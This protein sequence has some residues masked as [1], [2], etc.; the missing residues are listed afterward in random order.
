MKKRLTIL[1]IIILLLPNFVFA[2]VGPKP[3]L[4]I[5]VLGLEDYYLDLLVQVEAEHSWLEISEEERENL[6]T[7]ADYEDSQGYHPALL[8]GTRIPIWGEIVGERVGDEKYIH[9]FSYVGV[10]DN[11]KLAILTEDDRLIISE[12]MDRKHFQSQMTWDLRGI[13]ADEDI[14]LGV[15]DL[16]ENFPLGFIA[17]GFSLRIALTLIIEGILAY[18]FGFRS[19]ESIKLIGLTNLKTQVLLNIVIYAANLYGGMFMAL[20]GFV[21]MEIIIVIY[22]TKV[23]VRGLLEGTRTRRIS[24]GILANILSLVGGFLLA[25]RFLI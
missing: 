6:S 16:K 12:E 17:R 4:S 22:E 25:T 10:P 7:L 8:K 23:Y 19:R 14:N 21:L 13:D 3:S 15:G 1:L 20:L 5:E 11:F 18:M 2:D 9:E 24:Y